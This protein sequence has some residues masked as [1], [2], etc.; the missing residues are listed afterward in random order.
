LFLYPP[1][2]IFC[3]SRRRSLPGFPHSRYAQTCSDYAP[4]LTRNSSQHWP[5]YR[6][7]CEPSCCF[8]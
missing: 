1:N 6:W 5:E 4:H 7:A 2:K 3:S 8:R